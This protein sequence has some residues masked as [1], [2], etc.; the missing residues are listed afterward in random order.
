MQNWPSLQFS[1][2]DRLAC[3]AGKD[4][5]QV[6]ACDLFTEGPVMTGRCERVA[7]VSLSPGPLP[8]SVAAFV[9]EAKV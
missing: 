6:F 7:S 8:L 9:P 5:I 2:D 1:S 3:K 4:E